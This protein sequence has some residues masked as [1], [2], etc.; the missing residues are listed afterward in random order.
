[1]STWDPIS[2]EELQTQIADGE[3]Q[4]NADLRGVWDKVRVPPA[5]WQL[6]P[7]GDLGGGFWVVKQTKNRKSETG[8]AVDD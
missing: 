6:S 5:K 2:F 7:W 4:M 8:V 3:A 1:M